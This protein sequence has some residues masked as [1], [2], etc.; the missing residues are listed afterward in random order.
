MK[1]STAQK[2][3]AE[4]LAETVIST[5][6]GKVQIVA[7]AR[8]LSRMEFAERI[9]TLEGGG[10][11]TEA[12]RAAA[13]RHIERAATQIREYFEGR[14][15][16]F[17]LPLDLHGT[18]MQQRVW[19]RLL[20]VPFGQTLTY[21]ELAKRAGSPKAARAAGAACGANPVWLVVPCHRIVGSTGNLQGYGGGLWRKKALLEHEQGISPLFKTT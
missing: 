10:S 4:E 18:T 2:K 3:T 15:K 14:R 8:G 16:E 9:R 6:L 17:D 5:P 20:E 12:D 13:R 19:K 11:A 7:S 1:K 21:G